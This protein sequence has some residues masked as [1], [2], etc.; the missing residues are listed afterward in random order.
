MPKAEKKPQQ[1]A[2][3]EKSKEVK[4]IARQVVTPHDLERNTRAVK[5]LYLV[6]LNGGSGI[7]EKALVNLAYLM[8][9]SGYDLGYSF[10]LLGQNPSSRDLLNDLTM[11]KYLGFVE[12]NAKRKLVA[13]GLGKEF[14]ETHATII[15]DAE[16]LKN[17]F[18][19]LKP[20]I[21]PFDVEVDVKARRRA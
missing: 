20:K 19:E 2:G 17:L 9:Q 16:V 18:N 5:L 8:K 21:A 10:V 7:S 15:S 3:S 11:L 6:S 13:T 12:V 4:I 1:E 14:L